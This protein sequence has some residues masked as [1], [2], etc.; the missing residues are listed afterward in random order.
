[1]HNQPDSNF[2]GNFLTFILL[3]TISLQL[4]YYYATITI[5]CLFLFALDSQRWSL[6]LI[7][8]AGLNYFVLRANCET[9]LHFT[10]AQHPSDL[11]DVGEVGNLNDTSYKYKP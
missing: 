5:P 8:Q 11:N 10:F 3:Y 9:F 4:L 1:M 2:C 7:L 6:V